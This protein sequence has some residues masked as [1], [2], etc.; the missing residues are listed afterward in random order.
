VIDGAT[1]TTAPIGLIE[2][3]AERSAQFETAPAGKVVAWSI[4]RF[5]TSMV[6]AA[7][8]QDI[9]LVDLAVSADP[10]LEIVF[11]DT[12]FHFPETLEFVDRVRDRYGLNL[13]ITHPGPE[14]ESTPCGAEGC[15]RVR[16]VAP[17]RRAL[18]GRQA[19]LTALKRVDATTRTAAPIV[20]WDEG[21]GLVKVNPL[22]TWTED[23]IASY[24]ADHGLP[25]HPLIAQGY[26]SIG[27]AP[28]TR[29]V[30][31]GEDPRAGRWSGSDK[32]ECG[33]H[34]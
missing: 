12:G 8:F 9:V 27:C 2:E 28:T 4:E 29:P 3:L 7:S 6:V 10:S 5:G 21:F 26:L 20:S 14:A 30:A 23:D 11:L 32:T 13:T 31:A 25:A 17:L 15:C 16:K 22:A 19:W 33:L 24:L 34:G 1:T 18:A